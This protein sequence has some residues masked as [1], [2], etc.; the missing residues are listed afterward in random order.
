METEKTEKAEKKDIL[1]SK[2]LKLFIKS[3]LVIIGI[4]V[5]LYCGNVALLLHFGKNFEYDFYK[6]VIILGSPIIFFIFILIG[7]SCL[8][9]KMSYWFT[10]NKKDDEI[11]MKNINEILNTFNILKSNFVKEEEPIKKNL[12]NKFFELF[13]K[14]I[15]KLF[16]R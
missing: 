11:N 13:N 5:V 3:S 12:Q 2:S 1:N 16:K 14:Y 4:F 15:K 10:G 9:N 8:I 6:M 7:F